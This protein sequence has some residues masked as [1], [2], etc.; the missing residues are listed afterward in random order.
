M[1]RLILR[2]PWQRWGSTWVGV[3]N[4]VTMQGFD[5]SMH[6]GRVFYTTDHVIQQSKSFGG[7]SIT[8]VV[9]QGISSEQM[10]TFTIYEIF[11]KKDILNTEP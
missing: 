5:G 11:F 1:G 7:H 9:A 2:R 10:K 8:T 3:Q 4:P 6:A